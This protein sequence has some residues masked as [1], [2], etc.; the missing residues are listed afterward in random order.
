MVERQ[1]ND[2]FSNNKETNLIQPILRL[3]LTIANVN[4]KMNTMATDPSAVFM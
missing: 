2:F 1:I 3:H 4:N